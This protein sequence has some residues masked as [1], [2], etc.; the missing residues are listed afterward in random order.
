[1]SHHYDVV[2][3]SV[4]F[5]ELREINLTREQEE[6]E[7]DEGPSND[8]P[9]L[10]FSS[11]EEFPTE[12]NQL[13]PGSF[14]Y[15]IASDQGFPMI[16]AEGTIQ[17]QSISVEYVISLVSEDQNNILTLLIPFA[18]APG[19]V[20]MNPYNPSSI[21]NSPGATVSIGFTRITNTNGIIVIDTITYNT[22]IGSLFFTALDEDGNQVAFSGF[23][24]ELPLS[25]K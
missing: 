10:D 25:P 1:L 23:F 24:N 7:S 12:A 18:V 15:L 13:L 16:V 21:S 19:S 2:F 11:L 20:P 9:I 6:I 14:A 8:A 5:F 22:I 3:D 4:H 17:N